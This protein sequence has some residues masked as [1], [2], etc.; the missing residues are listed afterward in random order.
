V[1][2]LVVI[3]ISLN[4]VLGVSLEHMKQHAVQTLVSISRPEAA[5][6]HLKY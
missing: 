3:L 4:F 2:T 5:M 1:F 6:S